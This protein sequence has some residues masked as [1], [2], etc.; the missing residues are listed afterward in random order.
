MYRWDRL[1]TLQASRRSNQSFVSRVG[2]QRKTL[3]NP[4][5][6]QQDS[7]VHS[8]RNLVQ[9]ILFMGSPNDRDVSFNEQCKLVE[10]IGCSGALN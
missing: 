7:R 8:Y 10:S 4:Q 1:G 6:P 9:G 5:S 3:R 2:L